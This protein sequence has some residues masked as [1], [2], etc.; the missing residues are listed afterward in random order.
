MKFTYN[1][2]IIS[3]IMYPYYEDS[4]SQHK[5]VLPTSFFARRLVVR[6]KLS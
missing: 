4:T 5:Q 3:L 6:G 2:Y 1:C